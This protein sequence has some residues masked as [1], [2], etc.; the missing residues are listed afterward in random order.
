ML[1][2]SA[3]VNERKQLTSQRGWFLNTGVKSLTLITDSY[4]VM[5]TWNFV[6]V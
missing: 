5:R 4:V 1:P 6:S 3:E 2:E